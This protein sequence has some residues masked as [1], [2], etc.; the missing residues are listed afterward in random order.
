M[1]AAASPSRGPED[2][3][4]VERRRR[5]GRPGSK[6]DIV[7]SPPNVSRVIAL[8]SRW[9]ALAATLLHHGHQRWKR[10]RVTQ[11]CMNHAQRDILIGLVR[12]R[13]VPRGEPHQSRRGW[14][15]VLGAEQYCYC[16]LLR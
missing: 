8:S 5:T 12:Y 11:P 16:R 7:K 2:T 13:R 14:L 3:A 1:A 4:R 10:L 15:G 9:A 6:L